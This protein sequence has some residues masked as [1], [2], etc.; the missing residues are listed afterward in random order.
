MFT[1]FVTLAERK[2]GSSEEI[3]ALQDVRKAAISL[4]DLEARFEMR[5]NASK[6]ARGE[7]PTKLTKAKR[8]QVAGYASDAASL[9]AQVLT[10]LESS[11]SAREVL[12]WPHLAL[13][14]DINFWRSA[15]KNTHPADLP[16]VEEFLA[17]KIALH[18]ALS[19][20]FEHVGPSD[21]I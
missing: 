8:E 3:Q 1:D 19:E 16:L 7:A 15:H 14:N 2:C 21:D 20:W 11:V 5:V 4:D 12:Y 6:A 17:A 18:D 9:H 13:A 10:G